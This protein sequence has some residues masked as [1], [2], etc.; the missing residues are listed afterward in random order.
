MGLFSKKTIICTECGKEFVKRIILNGDYCD[1]CWQKKEA[2]RK[3]LED[4]VSGYQYY[5]SDVFLKFYTEDEMKAII[6][7]RNKLLGKLKNDNGITRE[8]LQHA[9]DNYKSLS[10]EQA[11]DIV[12]RISN[13]LLSTSLG[14]VYSPS[15]FCP[16]KYD[17]VIIDAEDIFAVGYTTSLKINAGNNEA[18]LCVV[19]TNDPY[20][21]VFPIVYI[22]KMGFFEVFKSK[23]GRAGVSTL[24]ELICP[25]LSYPIGDIKQLKKQIK[26]DRMVRGNLDVEFVIEQLDKAAWGS[27]IYDT[28]KMYNGLFKG[29]LTETMLEQIGYIEEKEVNS[30][31]KMNKWSNG[32]FWNEHIERLTGK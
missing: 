8:E 26:N 3:K 20:I 31:L 12:L 14:A 1:E 5:R 25:N 21:P 17:G 18:I 4:A 19:F 28:T 11:T 15:F 9:S 22:G 23:K 27:G 2:E 30:I 10:D 7:H 13:S 24:F 32:N 29:S 6:E 16:T